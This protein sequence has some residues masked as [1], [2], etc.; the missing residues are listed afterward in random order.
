MLPV[1][2]GPTARSGL[3]LLDP[4]DAPPDLD[5]IGAHG[6]LPEPLRRELRELGLL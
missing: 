1:R 4:K 5:R 2:L 6:Q 3:A